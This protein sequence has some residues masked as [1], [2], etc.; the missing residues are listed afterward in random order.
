MYFNN[1]QDGIDEIQNNNKW[2]EYSS[3]QLAEKL[4]SDKEW[5]DDIKSNKNSNTVVKPGIDNLLNRAVVIKTINTNKKNLEDCLARQ[6]DLLNDIETHLLSEPLDYFSRD[7]NPTLVL[8]Y[9]P[10][11]SLKKEISLLEKNN[12]DKTAVLPFI[13]R[14][15]KNILYFIL[16]I[17]EKGYVHLGLSPEHIIMLSNQNIRVVGINKIHKFENNQIYI[18]DIGDQYESAYMPPEFFEGGENGYLDVDSL[19]AFSLGVTLCQ[20]VCIK[21]EIQEFM[22]FEMNGQKDVF[23]YPNMDK[24]KE[25]LFSKLINKKLSDKRINISKKC[26]VKKL[27]ADLCKPNPKDRLTNFDIIEKRLNE[28][29]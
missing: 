24:Q 1:S 17:R 20:M 11:F 10:G 2:I 26:K 15:A 23:S 6:L 4:K 19:A 13:S 12:R 14:I 18:E 27:I 7:N 28:I 29:G 5:Y 16:I 21:S 8:D 3:S 22:T 9:H 25:R